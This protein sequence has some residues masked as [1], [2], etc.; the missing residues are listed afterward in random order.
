MP[1]DY[2]TNWLHAGD[3]PC[4]N[5]AVTTRRNQLLDAGRKWNRQLALWQDVHIRPKPQA[6]VRRQASGVKAQY[7]GQLRNLELGLFVVEVGF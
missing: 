4:S 3:T 2:S 7:L 6:G 1:L 5:Q